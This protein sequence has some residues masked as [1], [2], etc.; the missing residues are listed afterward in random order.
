MTK[1]VISDPFYSQYIHFAQLLRFYVLQ[2]RYL[3]GEH[4]GFGFWPEVE[5]RAQRRQRLKNYQ[6]VYSAE[7]CQQET[8]EKFAPLASLRGPCHEFP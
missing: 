2:K 5:R 6:R 1:H 7:T 3:N 4:A 8:G